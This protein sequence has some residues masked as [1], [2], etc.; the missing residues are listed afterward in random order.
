MEALLCC[1]Q[2]SLQ[3]H[4]LTSSVRTSYRSWPS[5]TISHGQP[6]TQCISRACGVFWFFFFLK[7]YRCV[8]SLKMNC[9]C[10][11]VTL[12]HLAFTVI[13]PRVS[14]LF[15]FLLLVD[16][17]FLNKP[18]YGKA[19]SRATPRLANSQAAGGSPQLRSRKAEGV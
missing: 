9:H 17:L 18:P 4:L 8:S 16:V 10:H 15:K 13:S 14:L 5:V 19:G 11:P 1:R 7:H 2:G 3:P 6:G 12:P